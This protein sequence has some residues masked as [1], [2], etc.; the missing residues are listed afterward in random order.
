[1]IQETL[2]PSS[3][4][5]YLFKSEGVHKDPTRTLCVVSYLT[6]GKGGISSVLHRGKGVSPSL[7]VRG[8][9]A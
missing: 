7:K 2:L 1:M 6:V 8:G 9:G 4:Y 5:C 3:S